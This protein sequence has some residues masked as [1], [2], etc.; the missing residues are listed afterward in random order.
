MSRTKV[1]STDTTAHEEAWLS[2]LHLR[3]R[4]PQRS[5]CIRAAHAASAAPTLETRFS[6]MYA[7]AASNSAH[8]PN[9][10][11]GGSSKSPADAEGEACE[12]PAITRRQPCLTAPRPTTQ[13]GASDETRTLRLGSNAPLMPRSRPVSPITW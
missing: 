2:P 9:A 6:S 1:P 12:G 4:S 8:A 10:L 13:K 5:A 7:S 11:T 3:P